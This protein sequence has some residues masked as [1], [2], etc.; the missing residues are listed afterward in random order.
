[1]KF[2]QETPDG[3]NIANSGTG[4]VNFAETENAPARIAEATAIFILT[5]KKQKKLKKNMK[6]GRKFES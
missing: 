3:E 5:M 6:A 4:I 1:M 2:A